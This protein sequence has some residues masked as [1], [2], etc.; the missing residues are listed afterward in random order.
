[1]PKNSETKDHVIQRDT[2]NML[3][4]VADPAARTHITDK[5]TGATGEGLSYNGHDEA[6]AQAWDALKSSNE[7][8][9]R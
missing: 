1:M 2:K 7:A 5:E 9:K 3:F 8:K 6:D 4:G